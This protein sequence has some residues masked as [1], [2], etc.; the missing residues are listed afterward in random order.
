MG[1]NQREHQPGTTRAETMRALSDR[2]GN[3]CQS[4]GA[5][6]TRLEIAHIVPI[7]K[8]GGMGPDNLALLCRNCHYL[9][10]A[11]RPSEFEFGRFLSEILSSS[12]H[13]HDVAAESPLR[14]NEGAIVWADLTATRS[15][16]GTRERVLIEAKSW[17][18]L[19]GEQVQRAIEQIDRYREAGSFDAAALV[20][21]G[22]IGEVGKASLEAAD[23]EV[24]DLDYVAEAFADQIAAQ[25]PSGFQLI[26]SLVARSDSR[27]EPDA[28][29]ARLR[30]CRV[31]REDWVK[32]QRVVADVF[33]F[34]F[35]PPLTPYTWESSDALGANRR[36]IVL[37]NYAADGFWKF[38]REVYRADYIVIDA[39]NGRNRVSKPEALQVANYLK[40]HGTGK[41]G[42][43]A[44]RS[45]ASRAGQHTIAEQWAL[46]GKMIVLLVDD[47]IERMLLAAGSGGRPEDV[48]GQKIESFRLAM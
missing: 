46:Y 4:C 1:P 38:L 35:V 25:P 44:T 13:Y 33:D 40:T 23:I 30:R 37:P 26:Y 45:G 5:E 21:P 36:D 29:I 15:P 48:I 31:G 42:I 24:W 9:L 17:S 7:A 28:L 22:R 14:T 10:D 41:F 19:G 47:D 12:P 43:I 18:S 2:H 16:N 32:Y 27:S 8:G 34:L 20:F 6:D 11:F 39:K 3:R